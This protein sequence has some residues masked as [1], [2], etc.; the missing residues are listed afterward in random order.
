MS[1]KNFAILLRYFQQHSKRLAD[2]V[3]KVKAKIENSNIFCFSHYIRKLDKLTQRQE[4][5]SSIRDFFCTYIHASGF[6]EIPTNLEIP[7]LS[8]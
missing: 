3:R 8:F 6:I 1:G 7:Q 2:K 5:K 4:Y